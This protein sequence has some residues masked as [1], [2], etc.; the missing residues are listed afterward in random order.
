MS[1]TAGVYAKARSEIIALFG[2]GTD[3]LTPDQS[4]RV[5]CAC[6]LRLALDDLQG[7]I[8]RGESADVARMLTASEALARLLPPTVLATPPSEPR[9]DPRQVMWEIYSTM[10]ERGEIDLKA[11]PDEGLQAKID[12]QAAEI[13]RLKAQLVGGLAPALPDGSDHRLHGATGD[14]PTLVESVPRGGSTAIDPDDIVPP[15]EIGECYA[16]PM[17]GPDDPPTLPVIEG[18][19]VRLSPTNPPAAPAAYD[20]RKSQ[21]WKNWIE[22]D[23]SI[24][25]TS[26]GPGRYWGPV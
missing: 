10:R 12:E 20:Y 16:G 14:V 9:A 13:D 18:K 17:P 19:A 26:R 1:I 23:G 21:D 6:A 3:S 4:L 24:R 2:W 7:R 22:P 11:I 25:T 8:V 5:D 15:G